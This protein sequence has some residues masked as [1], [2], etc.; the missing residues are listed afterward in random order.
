[1]VKDSW[2]GKGIGASLLDHCI[3]IGRE[4][5]LET[6]WGTVMAE[7]KGMLALGK[8]LGFD[9]KKS[10]DGYELKFHPGNS[11]Q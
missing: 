9:I 3:S 6:I 2:Q 10:P 1:V 4:W 8:S 11:C 7:N 5:E